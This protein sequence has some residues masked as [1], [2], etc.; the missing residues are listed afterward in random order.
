MAKHSTI[1]NNRKL[2]IEATLALREIGIDYNA[3]F[4]DVEKHISSL[5]ASNNLAV[6]SLSVTSIVPSIVRSMEYISQDIKRIT[7]A[8][9]KINEEIKKSEELDDDDVS[10]ADEGSFES[11]VSLSSSDGDLYAERDRLNDKLLMLIE[12]LIKFR[13][14]L[15]RSKAS[16]VNVNV[17]NNN[18][19]SVE[20]VFGTSS[21]PDGE[22]SADFTDV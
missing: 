12:K 19:K 13:K 7:V 18:A 15:Q 8:I 17:L 3:G 14:D 10:S 6:E 2:I 21:G 11:T 9:D 22:V 1:K 20:D 16:G 5:E 4:P